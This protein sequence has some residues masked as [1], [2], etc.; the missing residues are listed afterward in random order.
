MNTSLCSASGNVGIDHATQDTGT[1]A[2]I[3]PDGVERVDKR[4]LLGNSDSGPR[5][6]ERDVAIALLERERKKMREKDAERLPDRLGAIA[7]EVIVDCAEDK[8]HTQNLL[9]IFYTCNFSLLL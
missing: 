8:T 7:A 5:L 3:D 9:R 1:N 4:T 2:G 6:L